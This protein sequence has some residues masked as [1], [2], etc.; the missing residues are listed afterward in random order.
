MKID[1]AFY[2]QFTAGKG[3]VECAVACE[4]VFTA[5]INQYYNDNISIV[6]TDYEYDDTAGFR[7]ITVMVTDADLNDPFFAKMRNEWEGTIKFIATKNPIRPNHKRK[8]WYI[9]VNF[10]EGVTEVNV[11]GDGKDLKW[12]TM[13]ASGPGGQHV[14]V[15]NSA[16]KVTHIPTGITVRCE[17]QRNQIRNK[18]IA[19][20][21]LMA[22]I[23]ALNNIKIEEHKNLVWMN[24]NTVIRGNEVKTIKGEL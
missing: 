20:Q 17:A 19:L 1:K 11:L 10:F 5:W 3:P 12:E 23:Q 18:E 24:H 7:S 16:V 22:K 2:I 6:I 13:R 4:K 14:N 21:I 8:N 15:T 9:G